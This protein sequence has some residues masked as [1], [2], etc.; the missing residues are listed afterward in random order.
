LL[1][2]EMKKLVRQMP[3]KIFTKADG[4]QAAG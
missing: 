3:G 2:L 4:P 1:G